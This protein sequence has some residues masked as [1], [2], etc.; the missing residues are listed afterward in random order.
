MSL[1]DFLSFTLINI[2]SFSDQLHIPELLTRNPNPNP[3]GIQPTVSVWWGWWG[4]CKCYIQMDMQ[5]QNW[6]FHKTPYL[7]CLSVFSEYID[8]NN[9][10]VKLGVCWLHKLIIQMFLKGNV[11]DNKEN[12]QILDEMFQN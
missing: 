2:N 1:V 12:Q 8:S 9:C 10:F 7:N 4:W 5:E 11:I 6:F 3:V